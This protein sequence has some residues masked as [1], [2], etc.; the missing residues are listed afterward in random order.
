MM[1]DDIEDKMG[2]DSLDRRGVCK[3]KSIHVDFSI[4]LTKNASIVVPEFIG[5]TAS[6]PTECTLL[7]KII[8]SWSY[9][10]S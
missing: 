5:L 10:F 8:L 7:S 4:G 6:A 3:T 1:M 2:T 9:L